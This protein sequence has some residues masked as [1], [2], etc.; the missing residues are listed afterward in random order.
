MHYLHRESNP[1]PES[2]SPEYFR[3][4]EKELEA[5]CL[6]SVEEPE[7]EWFEVNV[8]EQVHYI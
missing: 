6:K 4:F 7:P 1:V 8:E 3:K 2:G 5:E